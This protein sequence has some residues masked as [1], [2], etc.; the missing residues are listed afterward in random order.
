MLRIDRKR[1]R[2]L[3][4][5]THQ[6]VDEQIFAIG[7][8][9]QFKPA[10][11]VCGAGAHGFP[12]RLVFH[13]DGG[14]L[15]RLAALGSEHRAADRSPG[16]SLRAQRDREA[17]AGENRGQFLF[18]A[19]GLEQ[20]ADTGRKRQRETPPERYRAQMTARRAAE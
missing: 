1:N 2:R 4:R 15:D 7:N 3:A 11:R 6:A 10:L 18:H 13:G 8:R 20:G 5:A 12:V 16:R 9:L 19:K 17:K 14:E